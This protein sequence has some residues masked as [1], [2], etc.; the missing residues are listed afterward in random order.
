MCI[1]DSV[2]DIYFGEKKRFEKGGIRH[3]SDV[4]SYDENQ[5]SSVAKLAFEAARKRKA[6]VSS[7]DKANVLAI[8]KL[9][10]E[11]VLEVA[12]DYQDIELEHILVDNC[13]MQLIKNPSQFDVILTPNMFGDILSDAAAVLPGSLGVMASAS[14]NSEGFGLFEPPG[15]SAQ[16]IAG[17]GVANP[18]GQILSLAMMFRFSFGLEKQA[19]AIELAVEKTIDKGIRTGDI[20]GKSSTSEVGDAICSEL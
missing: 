19:E 16:D 7:V 13:A 17:K 3:A 6:K 15:G 2:G 14:M 12:K 8:G 5:I 10:R 4:A 18:V 9:W 11:V 20:G 1:R